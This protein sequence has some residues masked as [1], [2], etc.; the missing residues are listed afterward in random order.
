MPQRKH[1]DPRGV[2]WRVWAT[3][4]ESDSPLAK[5]YPGGWLTFDCGGE[6]LRRIS[7]IPAGWLMADGA[8]LDLMLRAAEEVPRRTGE[9]LRA[10]RPSGF[11]VAGPEKLPEQDNSR[12]LLDEGGTP[13]SGA[14]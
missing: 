11:P 7:P 10:E 5:Y 4:P 13:D 12:E 6:T 2:E 8:R 14:F 3:K 1:T 9:R